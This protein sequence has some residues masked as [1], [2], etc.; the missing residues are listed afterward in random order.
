MF[1]VFFPWFSSQ[2]QTVVSLAAFHGSIDILKWIEN[3]NIKQFN[4]WL[5]N[6][7]TECEIDSVKVLLL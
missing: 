7:K 1:F 6:Q 2:Q 4:D 5:N 3:Y